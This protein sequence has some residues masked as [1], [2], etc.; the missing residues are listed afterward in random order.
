MGN[1]VSSTNTLLCIVG[2]QLLILGLLNSNGHVVLSEYLNS[3]VLYSNGPD[4]LIPFL[5]ESL[6]GSDYNQ[7]KIGILNHWFSLIPKEIASE[8]AEFWITKPE[9]I[10]VDFHL[11]SLTEMNIGY[12]IPTEFISK[13]TALFDNVT[14]HHLLTANLKANEGQEGV[15]SYK[16]HD[17]QFLQVVNNQKTVYSNLLKSESVL[18]QLYYSLLAFHLHNKDPHQIPFYTNNVGEELDNEYSNYIK[19]IHKTYP[20]I[21]QSTESDLSNENLYQLEKLDSCVS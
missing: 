1:S 18:S 20:S 10:D 17:L 16:V 2:E 12:Y 14:F 21:S 11:D 7:V 4:K 9:G 8:E 13:V 5:K 15:H 3:N 19:H 6:A